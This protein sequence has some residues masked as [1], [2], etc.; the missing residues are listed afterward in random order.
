MTR[1]LIWTMDMLLESDKRRFWKGPPMRPTED[2]IDALVP[3]GLSHLDRQLFGDI[4]IILQSDLLVK[5]DI[6]TMAAS[7]E[8]RSPLL[9]HR[10]IEF[11]ASLP[12]GYRIHRGQLK[13]LL[14]D[15]YA[16]QL[17]K[18]VIRGRKRGFE[19]PLQQW[20]ENDLRELTHDMLRSPSA[21]IHDYVESYFIEGLLQKSTAVKQNWAGLV[22]ALLMLEL[23]L[24]ENARR[25]RE[26][27]TS[28]LCQGSL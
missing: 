21:Y 18:E 6:A 11:T 27:A 9:D 15:A 4:Q 2:W 25:N 7:V 12:D 22:Y 3:A 14:R 28:S 5:M 10:L 23:W 26:I 17:P 13:S 1:Y 8:G 24:Q 16:E 19:I 20:L